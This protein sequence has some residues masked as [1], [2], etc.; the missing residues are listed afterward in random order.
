MRHAVDKFFVREYA[1]AAESYRP[2]PGAAVSEQHIG[3]K[4]HIAR[5]MPLFL[6][7]RA[8]DGEGLAT[9]ML[10]P[11]GKDDPRCRIIIVGANNADPYVAHADAIKALGD[12]YGIV[13]KRERC[14]P[15]G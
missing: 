8:D 1:A 2:R 15:Y 3:R 6:T 7:L 11:E 5:T 13:L 14:F 12:K 10:P 4:E 9:A